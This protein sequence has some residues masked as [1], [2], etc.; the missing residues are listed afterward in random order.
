V[1]LSG[2]ASIARCGSNQPDVTSGQT[3]DARPVIKGK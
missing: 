3:G 1:E 2:Q